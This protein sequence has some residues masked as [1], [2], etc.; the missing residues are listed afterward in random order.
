MG[1]RTRKLRNR[2]RRLGTPVAKGRGML[3]VSKDA[4]TPVSKDA[5]TPVVAPKKKKAT[6]KK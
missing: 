1:G 4:A 3:F 6:K 2:A 5:V